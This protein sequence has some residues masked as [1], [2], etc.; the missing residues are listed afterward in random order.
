LYK[1]FGHPEIICFGLKIN[2]MAD[3]INDI[4]DMVKAGETI[5]PGKPYTEVIGDYDVQFVQVDKAFYPNYLGY[6]SWFYG[7][8]HNYPVLQL[9]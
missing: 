9:V 2:V 6:A 8:S 1:N 4:R 5:A 3:L 7:N